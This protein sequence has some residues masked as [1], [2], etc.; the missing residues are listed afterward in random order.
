MAQLKAVESRVKN[1]HIVLRD[2]DFGRKMTRGRGMAVLFAG[3]SGTGKT[4]AAEVL[5]KAL[6]STCFRSICLPW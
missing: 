1:R 3:A 4:M 2:W 6:R 5:A